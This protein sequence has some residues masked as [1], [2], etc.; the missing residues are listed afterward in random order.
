MLHATNCLFNQMAFV[1]NVMV[2]Y[3]RGV[4]KGSMR[5]PTP[6]VIIVTLEDELWKQTLS[7]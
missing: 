2:T 6:D 4:W 3:L 5:I 1:S 7:K